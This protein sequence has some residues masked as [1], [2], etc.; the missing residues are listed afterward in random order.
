MVLLCPCVRQPA[1]RLRLQQ[2]LLRHRRRLRSRLR[3]LSPRRQ[4]R[5]WQLLPHLPTWHRPKELLAACRYVGVMRRP[6]DSIELDA[7]ERRL[8]GLGEKIRFVDAP[9]L[10]I[11]S[12]TIRSR[13]AN[14]GH[15][16]YYLTPGVYEYIE[17]E[18]LYR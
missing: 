3:R 8:P 1:R 11:S 16:R 9:Q 15:Y 12:S 18:R 6:G 10:D 7:L 14:G 2:P 17:R 5:R 13:V 4:L